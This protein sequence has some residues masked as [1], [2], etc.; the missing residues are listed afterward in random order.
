M[1]T[2]SAL[3]SIRQAHPSDHEQMLRIWLDASRVGHAFLGEDVL[4]AQHE[5]VRDVYFHLADHWLAWDE[6]PLG[7]IALLDKH[8]GGLFVDPEAH[9]CGVG[10][11]LVEHAAQRLGTLT[12]DVYERNVSA[13]AFYKRYG[14]ELVERKERDEEGREFALLELRRGAHLNRRRGPAEPDG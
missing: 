14:F 7:F 12:V 10:G 5:K 1:I 9:R 13:I 8:I 4:A 3:V 2:K 11:Q 6:R